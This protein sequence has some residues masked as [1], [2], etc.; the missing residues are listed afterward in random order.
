MKGRKFTP[1]PTRVRIRGKDDVPLSMTDLTQGLFALAHKLEEHPGYRVKSA[2]VYLTVVDEHGD[3]V[4]LAK[5]GQWSIY[6]YECFADRFD[7]R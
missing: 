6:P 4:T 5:T 1:K 3:E 2:T 7:P